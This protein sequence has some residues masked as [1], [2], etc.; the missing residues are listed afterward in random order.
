MKN[1]L[2]SIVIIFMMIY[3]V[4]CQADYPKDIPLFTGDINDPGIF[5]VDFEDEYVLVE[6]D[7]IVYWYPKE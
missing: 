2:I 4:P 7:G 1:W 3:V 5:I 6:S